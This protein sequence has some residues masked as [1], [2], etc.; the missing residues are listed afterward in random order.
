MKEKAAYLRSELE[1]IPEIE[2]L[3]GIGMM[4]GIKLKTKDAHDVMLAA[5]DAGLLVLTAKD[6]L[7][8]LPPLTITKEE[9]DA[10]LAILRKVLA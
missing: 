4:I 9:M 5:N 1:K 7:R 10:G 3:S 8:L 6:K 2:S